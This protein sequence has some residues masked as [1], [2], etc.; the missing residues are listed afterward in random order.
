MHRL[1]KTSS[2]FLLVIESLLSWGEVDLHV[3]TTVY[4]HYCSNR[5]PY[6]SCVT[7]A[8]FA[9]ADNEWSYLTH[10]CA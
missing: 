3:C 2:V 6:A 1:L 4:W 7:C 8:H 10:A 9:L 5:T